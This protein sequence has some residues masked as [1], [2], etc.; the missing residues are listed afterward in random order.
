MEVGP[1]LSQKLEG[2]CMWQILR[3]RVKEIKR[4]RGRERQRGREIKRELR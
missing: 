4:E 1:F 3:Q 2:F